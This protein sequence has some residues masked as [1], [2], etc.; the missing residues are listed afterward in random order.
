MVQALKDAGPNLTQENFIAALNKLKDFDP[1]IQSGALTFTPEQHAG[2]REGK[3]IYM[4]GA[5]PEIVSKYP[6]K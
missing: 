2:I 5:K 4:P 3:V 6:G 1:G